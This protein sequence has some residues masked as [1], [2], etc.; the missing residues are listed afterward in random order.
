MVWR[1]KQ[2]AVGYQASKLYY[3]IPE[4]SV[5]SCSILTNHYPYTYSHQTTTGGT[6]ERCKMVLGS[7]EMGGILLKNY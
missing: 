1:T 4:Q 6:R 2:E 5:S 7:L 3:Q